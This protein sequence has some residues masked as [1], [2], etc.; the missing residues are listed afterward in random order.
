[1]LNIYQ[2]RKKKAFVV[3]AF[4]VFGLG[5]PTIS[6]SVFPIPA[7]YKAHFIHLT[8]VNEKRLFQNS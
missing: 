7:L 2:W 6:K 8:A 3:V 1:M 4:G 5:I